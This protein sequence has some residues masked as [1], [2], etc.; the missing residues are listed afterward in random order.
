MKNKL[1]STFICES[2]WL[3]VYHLV[4]QKSN[5]SV[6]ELVFSLFFMEQWCSIKGLP[7]CWPIFAYP[8]TIPWEGQLLCSSYFGSCVT[9][10]NIANLLGRMCK[11]QVHMILLFEPCKIRFYFFR[12]KSSSTSLYERAWVRMPVQHIRP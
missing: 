5:L 10:V 6:T 12:N 3:S 8:E 4:Y 2:F 11:A 9:L 7:S 1:F